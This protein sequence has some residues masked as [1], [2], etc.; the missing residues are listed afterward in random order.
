MHGILYPRKTPT[1]KWKNI[2]EWSWVFREFKLCHKFLWY[3][4]Q[5]LKFTPTG[6]SSLSAS[7]KIAHVNGIDSDVRLFMS[8]KSRLNVSQPMTV[9]FITC[10]GFETIGFLAKFFDILWIFGK[11][12]QDW[13]YCICSCFITCDEEYKKLNM[14]WNRHSPSNSLKHDW[15]DI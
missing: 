13:C 9:S 7:F 14:N 2:F 8:W 6:G 1:Q 11:E 12:I 3:W 5:I 4:I 10:L 15:G